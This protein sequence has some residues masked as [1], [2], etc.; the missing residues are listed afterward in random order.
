M[1]VEI[2]KPA[3]DAFPGEPIFTDLR[4]SQALI[5]AIA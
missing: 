1:A 5:T 3:L 4:E 2:L